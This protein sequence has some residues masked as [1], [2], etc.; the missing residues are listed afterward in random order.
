MAQ[1]NNTRIINVAPLICE[2][3]PIRIPVGTIEQILLLQ[4]EFVTIYL[5]IYIGL[6]DVIA[7][8]KL[9][10]SS[11][12]FTRFVEK[13][14][15]RIASLIILWKLLGID[16]KNIHLETKVFVFII[17]GICSLLMSRIYLLNQFAT[18]ENICDSVHHH[19]DGHYL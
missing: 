14:S 12:K 1:L 19:K 7:S 10:I 3:K 18:F 9:F 2:F 13:K 11:S 5:A 16:S 8:E 17:V 15:K 4:N 6:T